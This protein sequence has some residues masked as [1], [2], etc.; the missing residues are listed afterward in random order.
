MC[1]TLPNYSICSQ[2]TS[3]VISSDEMLPMKSVV[4]ET[5]LG[6]L[7]TLIVPFLTIGT[8]ITLD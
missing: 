2:T 1:S 6:A 8:S 7:G 4:I 5:S 3:S